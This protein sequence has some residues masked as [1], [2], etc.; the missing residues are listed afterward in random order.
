[1]LA[2]SVSRGDHP[3][4][5]GEH[6]EGYADIDYTMGSSPHTRGA[7]AHGAAS[8]LVAG[9]IPAY[10]GSTIHKKTTPYRCR[11]HPR[12]RGEHAPLPSSHRVSGGS[13][14]HTRG[15]L[16]GVSAAALRVGIIPAYAGS[17]SDE[18]SGE[19]SRGDHPRIRGEHLLLQLLLAVGQ[20][21]S[22]HTRGA[23]RRPRKAS[24]SS[25]IIPAYAGSTELTTFCRILCRD[26]PRIRGEH[27]DHIVG[28]HDA[29]GSSPHTRGAL[30]GITIHDLSVGIIPAY[31]GSTARYRCSNSNRRDHPRIR[32]EHILSPM[33]TLRKRGSSPHTRGAP[34]H[35]KCTPYGAGIIPAYAGST[36]GRPTCCRPGGDHPRIRGEHLHAKTLVA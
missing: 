15:A 17:T 3:R 8:L 19:V 11:D 24:G 18:E 29:G 20:G 6:A 32:G 35:K 30:S 10:A 14:P 25:G 27:F 16:Q 26:H 21:S 4:I 12:I 28:R 31:A 1:M 7:L 13:S 33:V 23:P 2:P 34:K 22:P 36:A 5:R 9:I